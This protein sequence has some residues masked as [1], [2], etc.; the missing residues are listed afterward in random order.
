MAD[1]RCPMCGKP[2]PPETVICKF[3]QARLEPLIA[4]SPSDSNDIGTPGSDQETA[5]EESGILPDWIDDL[6]AEDEAPQEQTDKFFPEDISEDWTVE[7]EDEDRLSSAFPASPEGD[8]APDQDWL[9]RLVGEEPAPAEQERPDEPQTTPG[10]TPSAFFGMDELIGE[11]GSSD[12]L[13]E[14]QSSSLGLEDSLDS[15]QADETPFH[16]AEDPDRPHWLEMIR[17]QQQKE[18]KA[19]EA[20]TPPESADPERDEPSSADSTTQGISPDWLSETG[21]DEDGDDFFIDSKDLPDWMTESDTLLPKENPPASETIPGWVTESELPEQPADPQREGDLPDWLTSVEE[22]PADVIRTPSQELPDWLSETSAQDLDHSGLPEPLESEE[23]QAPTSNE[24]S[25]LPDWLTKLDA[26]GVYQPTGSDSPAFLLEDEQQAEVSDPAWAEEAP[27]EEAPSG[28]DSERDVPVGESEFSA[29]PEWLSQIS[30]MEEQSETGTPIDE[31]LEP[32][33]A[34]AQLPSWLQ[35]MR[36]VESA[37]LT[38][39][40]VEGEGSTVEQ[41]GPLAGL[42][43]VL[44]AEPEFIHLSKPKS[45]LVKLQVSDNQQSHITLLENLLAE[46]GQTK[47]VSTRSAISSQYFLRLLIAL[48]V[49]VSVILPLWMNREI[50]P[51]PAPAGVP[52]EVYDFGRLIGSLNANVPV[53]VAFDYEPGFS[54]ELDATSTAIL[55]E[56]AGRGIHLAA[57]STNPTGPLLAER[58]RIARLSDSTASF[59]NLGYI[60]GGAAGMLAFAQTPREVVPFDLNGARVWETTSLSTVSALADFGAVLV[61]TENPET[62]RSWIEQAQPFLESAGKPLLMVLSAQAE[63]MIRPYYETSPRQVSGMISGLAGGAAYESI[64]GNM[65]VSRLY[66]DAFGMGSASA[67]VIILAGA[68][69]SLVM[70]LLSK[71]KEKEVEGV[72]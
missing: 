8:F 50:L 44:S 70:A 4:P 51:M 22:T 14:F 13:A 7:S 3:C 17:A 67:V 63:P 12:W 45:S 32:D 24:E 58:F 31:E 40:S 20:S 34:E 21:I 33:L 11:E 19:G 9:S 47:P 1:V 43:G 57:I 65:G 49:L 46:E 26:S 68:L 37:A 53:L 42:A 23:E 25:G 39:P 54:G 52:N 60:P 38:A 30:A 69:V 6:R 15:S 5:S 2:N 48:V 35:A 64:S 10:S 36:P 41:A 71:P 62:A 16:S 28:E 29:V 18:S 56:M 61:L 66:W 72:L 59:V 55:S 27:S